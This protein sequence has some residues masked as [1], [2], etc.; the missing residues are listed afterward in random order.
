MSSLLYHARIHRTLLAFL[1]PS[2]LQPFLALLFP[3]CIIVP[4]ERDLF[5]KDEDDEA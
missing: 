3:L 2:T 4:L 5:D 1:V